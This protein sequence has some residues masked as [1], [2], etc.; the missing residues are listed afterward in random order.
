M[1]HRYVETQYPEGLTPVTVCKCLA[2]DSRSATM[3][4]PKLP[5]ILVNGKLKTSKNHAV[6]ASSVFAMDFSKSVSGNGW[7]VVWIVKSSVPK[8]ARAIPSVAK[9]M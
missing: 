9:D 8:A 4:V 3:N 7:I 2:L 1:S 6:K 5:A